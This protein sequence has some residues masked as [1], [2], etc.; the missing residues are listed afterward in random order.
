MVKQGL[1]EVLCEVVFA[2]PTVRRG[3]IRR[4][5][6]DAFGIVFELHK[7]SATVKNEVHLNT[8]IQSPHVNTQVGA[9]SRTM[10]S[11]TQTHR[12]TLVMHTAL[13]LVDPPEPCRRWTKSH[14]VPVHGPI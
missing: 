5:Q 7:R 13:Q 11:H 12:H 9:M 14:Y 3:L 2:Y 4:Q 1:V 8:H 10:T 6:L